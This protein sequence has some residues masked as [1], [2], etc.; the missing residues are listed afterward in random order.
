M[1][2]YLIRRLLSFIPTLMIVSII[3][4]SMLHLIPGDPAQ[5]ML[6]LTATP[7]QIEI[8]KEKLGLDRPLPVQY[9]NFLTNALQGDFGR[10]ITSGRPVV[11]EVKTRLQATVEL[12]L[13][14]ALL[15]TVLGIS[16]GMISALRRGS[17]VD[18]AST[19]VAIFGISLPVYWLGLMLM[20]VFAVKLGWL[21]SVGRGEIRHVILPAITLGVYSTAVISRMTRS[22]IVDLLSQDF[23]R[24]A[25]SKGLAERQVVFRHV[26]RNA[27]IPVIT[28]VGLQLGVLLSGAVVTESVFAWPGIGKL[29]VDAIKERDYPIVQALILLMSFIFLVVNLIVDILYAIVDPRIRYT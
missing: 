20:L 18:V 23:I 9:W 17:W 3:V 26:M 4:F 6:G 28:V 10:S 2:V 1:L 11:H 21:P 7:E 8:M 5:T 27:L 29:A 22:S 14:A 25:R 15:A 12:G 16:T 13:V 24:T 19:L